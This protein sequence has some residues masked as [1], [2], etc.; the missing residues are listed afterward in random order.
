MYAVC[1]LICFWCWP[2]RQREV[3]LGLLTIAVLLEVVQIFVPVRAF[4]WNDLLTNLAGVGAGAILFNAIYGR[5]PRR[6]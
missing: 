4:E 1:A 6:S 2:T 3:L 5:W